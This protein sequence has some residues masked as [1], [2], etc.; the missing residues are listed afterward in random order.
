MR[1][2]SHA[3]ATTNPA[4]WRWSPETFIKSK[5]VKMGLQVNIL[6]GMLFKP[7]VFVSSSYLDDAIT[8]FVNAC[9]PEGV[10]GVD[11]GGGGC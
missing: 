8:P 9:S 1:T 3:A 2:A 5:F 6:M 7:F 4:L 11:A 10:G